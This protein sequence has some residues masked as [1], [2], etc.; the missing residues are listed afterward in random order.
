MGEILEPNSTVIT[1]GNEARLKTNVERVFKLVNSVFSP[2][3][4]Q[5]DPI[6]CASNV[7][8]KAAA[9]QGQEPG[10]PLQS[11]IAGLS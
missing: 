6:V 7:H 4:Q 8:Y 10:S 3:S 1:S 11:S 2:C 5:Q 9:S